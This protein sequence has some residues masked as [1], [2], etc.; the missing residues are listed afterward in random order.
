MSRG[1]T[2]HVFKCTMLVNKLCC[3]TFVV[4]PAGNPTCDKGHRMLTHETTVSKAGVSLIPLEERMHYGKY[5]LVFREFIQPVMK[6][7]IPNTPSSPR[8]P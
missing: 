2:F 6:E 8:L 3:K 7:K 5:L 4:L 1:F